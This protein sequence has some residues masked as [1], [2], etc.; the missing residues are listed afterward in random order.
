MFESGYLVPYIAEKLTTITATATRSQSRSLIGSV[1][2]QY[3]NHPP[4]AST[5]TQ[6]EVPRF[7][8]LV[9]GL[10]ILSL[11]IAVIVLGPSIQTFL[12]FSPPRLR[13]KSSTPRRF[14]ITIVLLTFLSC[15]LLLGVALIFTVVV[16]SENSLADSQ[17]SGF[18]SRIDKISNRTFVLLRALTK[19]TKSVADVTVRGLISDFYNDLTLEVPTITAHFLNQTNLNTPLTILDDL[20]QTVEDL[21]KAHTCL[22]E[23]GPQV[24][25]ELEKLDSNIRVNGE[26]LFQEIQRTSRECAAFTDHLPSLKP[27]GEAIS[28]LMTGLYD[29]ENHVD[30]FFHLFHLES[31][32]G[33]FNMLNVLPF[34]VSTVIAQLKTAVSVRKELEASIRGR[35]E[36]RFSHMSNEVLK[37]V[38]GLSFYIDEALVKIDEMEHS[39]HQTM[40]HVNGGLKVLKGVWIIVYFIGVMV[41]TAP[42]VLLFCSCL[43]PRHSMKVAVKKVSPLLTTNE[44]ISASS[45]GCGSSEDE[46]STLTPIL[47]QER[48]LDSSTVFLPNSDYL[49]SHELLIRQVQD[50]SISC[51]SDSG[52][53][54]S[55]SRDLGVW[56]RTSTFD[57]LDEATS[58]QCWGA[59]CQGGDVKPRHCK[60]CAH[61]ISCCGL[62]LLSLICLPLLFGLG[63][64]HV[65]LVDWEDRLALPPRWASA[66]T[67]L[68]PAASVCLPLVPNS[69]QQL[70][71]DSELNAIMASSWNDWMRLASSFIHRHLRQL[72]GITDASFNL[73]N[74]LRVDRP[75]NLLSGLLTRCSPPWG[76]Q[77]FFKA[78]SLQAQ[79]N[80]S[81]LL[82]IPVVKIKSEEFKAY[83]VDQ[84][85]LMMVQKLE[86]GLLPLNFELLLQ[87]LI[88][89]TPN[90]TSGESGSATVLATVNR[91]W[92]QAIGGA[93]E[94]KKAIKSSLANL[95]RYRQ[96]QK[97]V[98]SLR[99]GL[100]QEL[101]QAQNISTSCSARLSQSLRISNYGL[102]LMRSTARSIRL[103]DHLENLYKAATTLNEISKRPTFTKSI[104]NFAQLAYSMGL[105]KASTNASRDELLQCVNRT[106]GLEYERLASAFESHYAARSVNVW[107]AAALDRFTAPCQRLGAIA[108]DVVG[109]TCII[110]PLQ[111]RPPQ[112]QFVPVVQRVAAVGVVILLFVSLYSCLCIIYICI[113]RSFSCK[114]V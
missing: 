56:S 98:V 30:T 10:C 61:L 74:Y 3:L 94:R 47:A 11:S 2:Y 65:H 72:G 50:S 92:L 29:E 62:L 79:L 44:L 95:Q 20:S 40:G 80:F 35:I 85:V 76:N 9:I 107:I 34:N 110:S 21:L 26:M 73:T 102:R 64:F 83:L 17:R 90:A 100:E 39:Y 78:I 81:G 15:W 68:V 96:L 104:S 66:L 25:L 82:E 97:Q 46:D 103:K 27:F 52:C 91:F 6:I 71:L 19:E 69:P 43:C 12:S 24:T 89:Q 36:D 42:L 51:D 60:G 70:Q 58:R 4:S 49:D 111:Q 14:C 32:L 1:F 75:R 57:T 59:H 99:R 88:V 109:S 38:D 114:T 55:D 16:F 87:N 86:V 84:A 41:I 112:N 93:V 108:W 105:S 7:S 5:W 77:S 31:S 28:Q 106:I 22:R 13:K 67:S 18:V 37:A 101:S 33:L 63:Y 54:R 53:P 45:S 113:T 23:S 8:T 48:R